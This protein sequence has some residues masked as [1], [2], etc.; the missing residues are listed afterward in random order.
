MSFR[1]SFSSPRLRALRVLPLLITALVLS[2]SAYGMFMVNPGISPTP[3]KG[4]AGTNPGTPPATDPG[5]PGTG[6]DQEKTAPPSPFTVSMEPIAFDT[7]RPDGFIV[8]EISIRNDSDAPASVKVVMRFTTDELSRSVTTSRIVQPHSRL[9][10]PVFVPAGNRVRENRRRPFAYYDSFQSADPKVYINGVEYKSLPAAGFLSGESTATGCL[11]LPSSFSR[12]EK[13]A[14]YLALAITRDVDMAF[15]SDRTP[16]L[17]LVGNEEINCTVSSSDTIQWPAIPQFYQSNPFIFRKSTDKFT[18]EAERAIRDAVMLGST[19]VLIV[20]PGDPWPE[21]APRP[22]SPDL[23]SIVARGFGQ[24]VVLDAS[25]VT[26][27]G[28]GRARPPSPAVRKTSAAAERGNDEFDVER[29]SH[30]KP[31]LEDALRN[32]R[33]R[34]HEPG[35]I[36]LALPYMETPS[37]PFYVIV[38]SLLAYIVLVGPFNYF[39][40]IRRKKR[41]V[42]LLLVTIPLISL[43][44]VALV[45]VFVGSVEGWNPRASAVGVTF[46]DQRENMAYTRAA[47]SLYAPVPIRTLTFDSSESVQFSYTNAANL[48]LGRDQLVTGANR[49]RIPLSYSVSRAER[50]LEQLGINRE[51][52]GSLSVVNGLGVPLNKLIVKTENGEVWTASDTVAPGKSVRLAR[53][54][55]AVPD[56]KDFHRRLSGV[57]REKER[58]GDD[59]DESE[60]GLPF[61]SLLLT[62]SSILLEMRPDLSEEEFDLRFSDI[63]YGSDVC[64]TVYRDLIP[65][66]ELFAMPGSLEYVLPPGMYMAETDSPL[67]YSTGVRPSSFRAHHIVFGTFTAQEASS[68]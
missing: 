65:A 40:L 68:K 9:T 39:Y 58:I 53:S 10:I 20:M 63:M 8:R 37:I 41:S 38:I 60:A 4:P 1:R 2:A 25:A 62:A 56:K 29:L 24:S 22:A 42:L 19:E 31:G 51:D 48:S 32:A 50:H 6:K 66:K 18:P 11:P 27:D 14:E 26:P 5:V 67:F 13:L 36:F 54:S 17:D 7:I 35:S 16:S 12:Q 15:F 47:V 49:A 34:A 57:L 52:D 59:A 30:A 45:I 3:A 55:V 23:P 61:N 21:W 28:T 46:L 43:S 44:F 33:I 64:G